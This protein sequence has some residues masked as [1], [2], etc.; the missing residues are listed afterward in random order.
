MITSSVF[1]D[2]FDK[3][4]PVLL[5]G[6]IFIVLKTFLFHQIRYAQQLLL[7]RKKQTVRTSLDSRTI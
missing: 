1:L 5:F 7:Q 4:T 3:S 6:I 2:L